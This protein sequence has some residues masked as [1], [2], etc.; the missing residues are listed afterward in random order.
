[1]FFN[2]TYLFCI[3]YDS[4]LLTKNVRGLHKTHQQT[5]HGPLIENSCCKARCFSSTEE[6]IWTER[7]N[8]RRLREEHAAHT[9]EMRDAH[10]IVLGKPEE[11]RPPER[12]THRCK[13]VEWIHL[14]HDRVQWSAAVNM[15]M[16]I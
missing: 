8:N 12:P 2:V 1:M 15:V 10:K 5:T 6:N 13:D 4:T 3:A 16:H 11:S 14:A 7:G 9:G